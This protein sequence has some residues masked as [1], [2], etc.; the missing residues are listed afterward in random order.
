MK[1]TTYPQYIVNGVRKRFFNF[2]KTNSGE[3]LIEVYKK[4]MHN[5]DESSKETLIAFNSDFML[6]AVLKL[7]DLLK[8]SFSH[9]V[10]VFIRG[11]DRV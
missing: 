5:S 1:T 7:R 4:I 6:Q 8:Q 9:Q 2:T 10:Y 3:K 11:V